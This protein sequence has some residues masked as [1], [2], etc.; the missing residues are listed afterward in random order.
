MNTYRLSSDAMLELL[1][2]FWTDLEPRMKNSRLL[3]GVSYEVIYA[4]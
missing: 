3:S 2:E 4:L 1:D